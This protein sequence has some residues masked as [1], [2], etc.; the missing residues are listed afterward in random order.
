MLE[1]LRA[2]DDRVDD[3]RCEVRESL[4]VAR[5]DSQDFREEILGRVSKIETAVAVD[6][7][8]DAAVKAQRAQWGAV[9]AW[10]VGTLVAV[11]AILIPLLWSAL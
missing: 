7:A 9:A 10:A 8:A 4:R 2:Q 3:F 11:A 6:E 1:H 5:A